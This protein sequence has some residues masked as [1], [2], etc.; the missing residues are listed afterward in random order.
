[1]DW[2]RNGAGGYN[3][4]TMA[5]IGEQ[6]ASNRYDPRHP[7]YQAWICVYFTYNFLPGSDSLFGYSSNG[8]VQPEAFTPLVQQDIVA[9]LDMMGVKAAPAFA[10]PEHNVESAKVGGTATVRDEFNIVTL[11]DVGD[12]N[13]KSFDVSHRKGNERPPD[14]EPAHFLPKSEQWEGLVRSYAPIEYK[15]HGFPL[16]LEDH[17]I[18]AYFFYAGARYVVN[19]KEVDTFEN[20]KASAAPVLESGIDFLSLH[21]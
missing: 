17:G 8:E 2:Y 20:V 5:D 21:L 11:A 14:I 9:W 19:N 15:V 16:P 12:S 4:W 7:L 3:F 1:M 13:P 6:G 18:T 10:R